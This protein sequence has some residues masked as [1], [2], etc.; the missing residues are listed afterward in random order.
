MFEALQP[1]LVITRREIRDQFRDW[2]IYFPVIGLT[3]FFPFLMN[4]T[5]G[6]MLRFVEQYGANI[7]A[8]R[9]IPFFLLIVGFFPISV[10]LVIALE[11]FVGEKERGSIEPLLN[12]PLK[13]WQLYLG[14]LL[15]VTVPPLLYSYIGM[16][17]YLLGLY[18]QGITLPELPL[19]VQIITLT[20]VQAVMM[21]SGAVV[22]STQATSV[23]SANL[24]ASFIIIPTA[25]LIQGESVVMFWGNYGTLWW[26]VFGLFILSILL[27]RVGLAHFQREELLGREL[28]V[29]NFR[30]IW[31]VY[32]SAFTGGA[33]SIKEWYQGIFREIL[34]EMRRAVL[35]VILIMIC[36]A[37]VGYHYV[38][39]LP[40]PLGTASGDEILPRL[41]ALVQFIPSLGFTPVGLI[42]WQNLRVML[43]AL[44]AGAF[45]LG[46]LGVM[47]L[48]ATVG[49]MGYLAG[50]LA[51]Q[52]YSALIF[53][54][55]IVPHGILEIPAA[56]I[57]TA[58]VLQ[59]GVILATPTPGKTI[60]EAWLG[61]LANWT[62]LM[63]GVVLPLVILAAMIEVWI[64]P[65]LALMIFQ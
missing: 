24:L 42:I 11:S 35:V 53:A 3:L 13:D 9:L 18:R 15:A 40:L 62:R 59:A 26:V 61:A 2:R 8:D 6:Q 28:D 4:F 22:V 64:T 57:S 23:R 19:L 44:L 39:R 31:R 36:G 54:G 10:S 20:T 32:R 52:G 29:L 51:E 14:K 34:P 43:I 45:T 30:W 46:V 37:L 5:A 41:Q 50:T 16:G 17:V 25:L 1:A 65:R 55:L 7:I 47:P 12:S 27:V 33:R 58:A 60:G 56:I 49:V 48:L 21:V 63:L 38:D